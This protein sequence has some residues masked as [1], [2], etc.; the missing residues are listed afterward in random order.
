MW[1]CVLQ[2]GISLVIT[3]VASAQ[4]PSGLEKTEADQST[5]LQDPFAMQSYSGNMLLPARNYTLPEGIKVVGILAVKGGSCL[6]VLKIPE[7]DDYY[8]VKEGDLVQVPQQKGQKPIYLQV[9]AIR[10]D[11][12]E[13]APYT[14]PEEVRIYR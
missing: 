8:F 11:S 4:M 14:R 7:A 13:I 3:A 2:I 10:A 1:M 5:P 9:Q 6:G 12:I